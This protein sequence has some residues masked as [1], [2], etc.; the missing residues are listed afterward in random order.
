[1]VNWNA[2][3]DQI[4]LKGIFKFHDIKSSAPLLKYLSEQIG[5]GCTP[6]AVSHRLNNI[7]NH[8]KP[9]ANGTSPAKTPTTPRT[10][11]TPA[12]RVKFQPKTNIDTTSESE[13]DGPEGLVESPSARR[14][15]VKRAKSTP[16]RSYAESVDESV[17]ESQEQSASEPAAKRPRVKP[18]SVDED[19]GGHVP[20][21]LRGDEDDFEL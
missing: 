3:K 16:K 5:E 20:F 21:G 18:E 9:L 1:M 17:D 7:R 10:P 8:G 11:K 4:I 13:N 6:K 19:A 15:S 2:E 14:A 12:S